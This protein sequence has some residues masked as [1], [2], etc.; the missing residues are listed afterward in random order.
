MPLKE[1]VLKSLAESVLVPLGLTAA[2]VVT[3]TAIQKKT[4]GS[5]VTPLII[6]NN[7]MVM[8]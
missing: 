5:G 3:D 4:V 2:A 8:L 1:N 7:K 6:S